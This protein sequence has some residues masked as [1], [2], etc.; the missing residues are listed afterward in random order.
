MDQTIKHTP[1]KFDILPILKDRW[2]PRTFSDQPVS[3]TQ[4]RA[5]FEAG[6][7]APS[8]YNLQ[9]WR[10]IWGIKGSETYDRIKACLN[11]FNQQWAV[12]AP[13]LMLGAYKTTNE[14]GEKNSHAFHDLGLFMGNVLCQAQ[15]MGIALHQMAGIHADKAHKEFKFPDDHVV[16]TGIAVGYYGGSVTDLPENLREKEEKKERERKEQRD[17]TFN[18]NY[19][20]PIK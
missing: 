7:W 10:I 14:Q 4:L 16:A 8:A 2:S 12:N 15:H 19:Q 6:R 3:E 5:L 13:V 9:P 17:F 20:Q 11:D 1:T 18:G